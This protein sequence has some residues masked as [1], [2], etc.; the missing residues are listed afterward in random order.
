M[1]HMG[2]NFK[3]PKA[4]PTLFHKYQVGVPWPAKFVQNTAEV[5]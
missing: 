3:R 1:T 5:Q 4:Y 2:N